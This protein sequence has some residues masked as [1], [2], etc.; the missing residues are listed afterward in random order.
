MSIDA[1]EQLQ[2]NIAPY[3]VRQGNFVGAGINAV[4]KS[5]TNDYSASIYYQTRNE[6]FVGTKA[7]DATY[8]PG[9]FKFNMFG[10]RLGGPIIENKLFFFTNFETEDLTQPGT[11]YLA[12]DGSQ[13]EGGNITRVLKSDLDKLSDFLR[14]KFNYE[15][16]P[17]QGYNFQTPALR[18]IFRLDYNIDENNKI[19][20]RYN[21]LD[22]KSD[23][24]LSNSSSLGFGNRRSSIQALNFKN[25]NY[26]ILE[27]IRSIIG[28]WNSVL[29]NNMTNSLILG[30][31]FHDESREQPGK[32]F[33]FVD[34]LKANTTY[35]SFGTEP[36]TPDNALTYSTFQF[37]NNFNW[38]MGDHN[39]LFG[40]SLEWY[41]SKNIFFPGSQSVYVYNS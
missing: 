39:L 6:S 18:F 33:P 1:L 4:T 7:A 29:S 36:F 31:R 27:N 13:T 40:L 24:L 28:E 17:Y 16:G 10:A 34:I 14:E 26:A 22:S 2:V 32:L 20:L 9:T 15:T 12:N 11:Y 8:N 21:H 41:E 38:F 30:Y 5:G 25:S 37:Q 3:D 23:I 35:T 19:N